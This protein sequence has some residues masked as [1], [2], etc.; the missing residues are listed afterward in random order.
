M[1]ALWMFHRRLVVR[2]SSLGAWLVDGVV[3]AGSHRGTPPTRLSAVLH[4][5]H[6][7]QASGPKTSTH[8]RR[9]RRCLHPD[10][11]SKGVD[12]QLAQAETSASITAAEETNIPAPAVSTAYPSS[13]PPIGAIRGPSPLP[14]PPSSWTR[15][16]PPSPGP[17]SWPGP[18]TRRRP[19]RCP[20]SRPRWRARRS[21]CPA[22]PDLPGGTPSPM[23]SAAQWASDGQ[24][25]VVQSVSG[26]QAEV[27]PDWTEIISEGWQPVTRA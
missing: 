6:A 18:S 11:R 7:V 25:G 22:D 9:R 10:G 15:T 14:L 1:R 26:L 5:L 8:R 2:S 17:R 24:S 13:P 12:G 4:W 23:P 27:D 20:V 3:V 16:T 19:T 21:C